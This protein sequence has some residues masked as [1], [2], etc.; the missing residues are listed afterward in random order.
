MGDGAPG[1]VAAV[2][3]RSLCGTLRLRVFFLNANLR[4]SLC[5]IHNNLRLSTFKVYGRLS[6]ALL[7]LHVRS[8]TGLLLDFYLGLGGC[9]CTWGCCGGWVT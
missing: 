2:R 6:I 3:S 4:L 8:R 7:D 1:A 9:T 5:L